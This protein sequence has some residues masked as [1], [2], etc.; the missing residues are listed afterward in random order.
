MDPAALLRTLLQVLA[1]SLFPRLR[2]QAGDPFVAF[3]REDG[4]RRPFRRPRKGGARD[5]TYRRFVVNDRAREGEPAA[6]RLG[7]GVGDPARVLVVVP[8][9][10]ETNDR[11]GEMRRVGR[12][13]TLIVDY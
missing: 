13:P 2:F 6:L 5:G 4:V 9:L 12:A 8:A 3:G 1:Q 11:V 7:R 10:R